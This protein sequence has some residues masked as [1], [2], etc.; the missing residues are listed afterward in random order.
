MDTKHYIKILKNRKVLSTLVLNIGVDAEEER[1]LFR[2]SSSF[3]LPIIGQFYFLSFSLIVAL[4]IGQP[5]KEPG[6]EWHL[7]RPKH[8]IGFPVSS[9]YLRISSRSDILYFSLN[10]FVLIYSPIGRLSMG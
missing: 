4:A 10:I 5:R 8:F 6:H 7:Q 9:S 3:C 2:G 1:S